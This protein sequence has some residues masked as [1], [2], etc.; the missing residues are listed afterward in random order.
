MIET[1]QMF[2][3]ICEA[4][5]ND[6]N[7]RSYTINFVND[8]SFTIDKINV[9]IGGAVSSEEHFKQLNSKRTYDTMQPKSY[10]RLDQTVQEQAEFELFYHFELNISGTI[11]R[12]HFSVRS[13]AYNL[14]T[15][16]TV[17]IMGCSGLVI[18]AVEEIQ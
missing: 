16:E 2:L 13:H 9:V 14:P 12:K 10:I 15:L 6:E 17:P 7:V 8:T 18:T 3:A 4:E 11:I 5:N 1:E